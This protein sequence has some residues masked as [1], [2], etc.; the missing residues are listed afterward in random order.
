MR[1]LN[2]L[3]PRNS[4]WMLARAHGINDRGQIVGEGLL[5][6]GA[7]AFLLIPRSER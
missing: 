6:G 3:I 1:D 5:N 4:G 7:A 2:A